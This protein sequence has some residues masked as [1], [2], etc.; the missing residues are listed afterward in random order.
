MS[1]PIERASDITVAGEGR[2]ATPPD[3]RVTP[4]GS[5]VTTLFPYG[6]T[7][8]MISKRP[9]LA[10]AVLLLVLAGC[11]GT[12]SENPDAEVLLADAL[13]GGDAEVLVGERT[14]EFA[15]EN[16][17]ET[18][19]ERVWETSDRY[20]LEIVDSPGSDDDGDMV[21][22]TGSSALFYDAET[23][24]AIAREPSPT[25]SIEDFEASYVGTDTVAGR[26][27]HVV[28]AEVRTESVERGIGV[29]VGDTRYV[30]PLETE[31][32]DADLVERRLWIDEEYGY[33]LKQREV[34]E[35]P[36]ESELEVTYT[37]EE[38]SFKGEIDEELLELPDDAEVIK[39]ETDQWEFEDRETADE[40][41]PFDLPDAA[42]PDNYERKA[43]T[44]DEYD[45][46]I[47]VHEEYEVGSE[48][49]WYSVAQEGLMPE[50]PDREGVGDVNASV[51]ELD[52][53]TLLTWECGDFEV[54]L[55]GPFDVETLLELAEGVPCE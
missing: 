39:P 10:V 2:P 28:D 44:G 42:F 36:D 3:G 32:R 54:E 37:F 15:D 24:E 12:V 25:P 47:T 9:V 26:D 50:D 19:V 18:A 34:Y 49:L 1:F 38:V 43:V 11:T 40:A 4:R 8:T 16:G 23:G 52:G 41:V 30:Y 14:V 45:G 20:R 46:T 29:L 13:E 17:V 55:S 27:V 22:H 48:L 31:D 5:I 33:A 6:D 51:V 21:V 53:P 7:T 35:D